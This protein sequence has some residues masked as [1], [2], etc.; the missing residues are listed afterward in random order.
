MSAHFATKVVE[1][2]RD[3]LERA[4]KALLELY[5]NKDN[6]MMLNPDKIMNYKMPPH[7]YECIE[8]YQREK[9]VRKVKL[10]LWDTAGTEQFRSITTMYFRNAAAAIV[11]YD[12]TD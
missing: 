9:A 10:Q 2:D 12:V 5:R 4:Q 7:L 6:Q 11:V 1:V 3:N 8:D